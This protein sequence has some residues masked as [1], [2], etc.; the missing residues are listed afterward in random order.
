M[1]YTLRRAE[2]LPFR[3]CFVK[4][5]QQPGR[6]RSCTAPWLCLVPFPNHPPSPL[7]VIV[8]ERG[9]LVWVFNFSPFNTYEG[10]QVC[11]QCCV[12]CVRMGLY[13]CN[14]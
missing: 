11:G 5:A 4:A 10:L 13:G 1:P 12:G 7:Q 3:R 2:R 6:A 8:A 14:T 9:P